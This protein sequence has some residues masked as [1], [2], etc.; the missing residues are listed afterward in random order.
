M[1]CYNQL[2]GKAPLET[3][4][5][6]A[7]IL[8]NTRQ[9]IGKTICHRLSWTD[10]DQSGQQTL[11]LTKPV[12]KSN[13]YWSLSWFLSTRAPFPSRKTFSVVL[14]SSFNEEILPVLIGPMLTLSLAA[15]VV[16]RVSQ[17]TT[18]VAHGSTS[19]NVVEWRSHQKW[20]TW[21]R[22]RWIGVILWSCESTLLDQPFG[23]AYHTFNLNVVGQNTVQTSYDSLCIDSHFVR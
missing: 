2:S 11:W 17:T 19:W 1:T 4:L 18:P 5:K 16:F 12:G 15:I 21:S 23:R 8:K 9:V 10:F 3:I 22:T 6:R 13:Y 20:M 14:C 7:R